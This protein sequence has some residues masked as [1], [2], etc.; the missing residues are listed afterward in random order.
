M[1]LK[2]ILSISLGLVL[3]L[4]ASSGNVFGFSAGPPDKLTGAPNE[5][6]CT[7]C[8]IGNSLN[9]SGGSLIL[10]VPENYSPGEV[11]DIVVKLS[12]AE[13]EKWGF[14]MTALNSSGTRA[15]TFA[16]ADGNTQV[17]EA[18]GKQYIKQTFSGTAAGEADSH[19]WTFRWTA[20]TTDVGTITFYAAGNAANN[21]FTAGEDY[22]YTQKATSDIAPVYGLTLTGVGAL[23]TQTR[24]A[25]SG[26]N[27]TLRITNTG[28][29][30]DT[31]G[32]T[33]SG[34]AKAT[35]SHANV[36][37]APNAST[38]VT[39]RVAGTAL[40][41]A[42]TYAVKVTATSQGDSTKN[43]EATT[44]TTILPVYDV[45]LA[46]V[47]L[48]AKESS[49]ASSGV[50]YTL[51]I[52]NTGNTSDT[53]RLSTSGDVSATLSRTA[54]S[55]ERGA[56]TTVTVTVSGAA[57]SAAGTYAVKVTATSQGDSTKNADI[58]TTTTVL[59]VYGVTL[60]GVGALSKESSDASSGVSYTLRITNTG[61]TND[62]FRLSTS[63]DVSATVSQSTVSLARGA[64][65][66]V[67]LTV[68][69]PVLSAA[70]S[71]RCQSYG[72]LTG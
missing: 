28:N 1:Y 58:T 12:R 52:T 42:G 39:V 10:T 70:G 65:T 66:E 11:Y 15:G 21:D 51:R 6:N 38:T 23:T 46:G 62:A 14:E 69:D 3:F 13:Q 56:S 68:S 47:G 35:L 22:I 27:Y 44:T 5:G 8:H 64:A 54:V 49:D 45:A 26:V 4:A 43:A 20:P 7:Q 57:L 36:S 59:P 24:D 32:L 31:F 41:A 25:S 53:F 63:G 16:T 29:A 60:A 55:L 18:G 48:L 67:T 17:S 30:N 72:D 40:S 34:N 33:T 50:S 37:L 71:Y 9:R 61:N 19:S 2:N